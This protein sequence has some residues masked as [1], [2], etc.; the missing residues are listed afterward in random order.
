[1]WAGV[2]VAVWRALSLAAG[3]RNPHLGDAQPGEPAMTAQTARDA[4]VNAF[5]VLLA[6]R[7]YG[8]FDMA[9]VAQRAGLAL[10]EAR[11]AFADLPDLL[12]GFS[13]LIDRQVLAEGGPESDDFAGEGPHER[14]FEVL[15]RR[16]D[17]LE[18][19]RAAIR[20]LLSSARRDPLLALHLLRNAERSQRWMLAAAGIDGAGLRGAV[21][22][23]GLAA[24]FGRVVE[25]WLD[26]E[27][28]GLSRTMAKLD[29]DLRRGE[30]MLGTLDDLAFLAAPWRRNRR[31][32]PAPEPDGPAPG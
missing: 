2:A 4:L 5:L 30:K 12:A 24:L 18:P 14:L 20:S 8:S 22:A 9:E 13:R 32:A 1:M 3:A 10:A 23:K 19:H 21:K 31:A 26:D 28:P 29:E 7:P 15:M 17:A 6:E 11:S 27:D 25:T 16:L